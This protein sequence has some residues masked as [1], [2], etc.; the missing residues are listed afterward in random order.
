MFDGNW[1]EARTDPLSWPDAIQVANSSY[2]GGVQGHLVAVTTAVEQSFIQDVFPYNSWLDLTD[3]GSGNEWQFVTGPQ[4]GGIATYLPFGTAPSF[5]SPMCVY[6]QL[7]MDGTLAWA[8]QT[9]ALS[10]AYIVEYECP[11]G[12][13]LTVSGCECLF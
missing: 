4:N 2:N 1:Y 3:A 5:S 8:G 9:C 6:E 12:Q 13:R 7:Q 11:E 10:L